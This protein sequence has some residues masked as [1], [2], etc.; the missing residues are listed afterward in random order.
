M[1]FVSLRRVVRFGIQNFLRNIWLS[2]ATVSVLVLT[3]VSI[4]MLVVMNV[5]AKVALSTVRSKIDVS[6]HFKP[7]VEESRVQTV[8][9]ALLSLPEV[10][11]VEYVSPADALQR[12]SET[13]KKDESVLESLGEVG[14][15]P[16]GATL[17]VKARD[18]EGYPKILSTL[19]EPVFAGLI[20]G[21]D[22][23]DR[24]ALIER[25]DQISL[26]I[27]YFGIA[28]SAVFGLIALLIILNTIR[29]SIYTHREEIGIMRLVGASDGFIRAPFYVEAVLWSFIALAITAA[30]VYPGI[31]FSQ[32]F[33]QRFFGTAEMDLVGF[34]GANFLRVFGLQL[35]AVAF[36]CLLTTKM[37]T[38]RYLK[39]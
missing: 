36:M 22:F 35:F 19:G 11:D 18:L 31:G 25:I 9:I 13:Y 28:I 21:K 34:Y 38:A 2:V 23:D 27:E 29:V 32:P 7:E 4:N 17:I 12:F 8:K 26:R 6:V 33:L 20:E 10:K 30:V 39:V 14:D 15:N 37:A 3:L 16:F 1:L 5:M 24:Q